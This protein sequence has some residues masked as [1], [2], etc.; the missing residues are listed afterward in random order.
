MDKARHQR[1]RGW[2][3]RLRWVAATGFVCFVAFSI[4]AFALDERADYLCDLSGGIALLALLIGG[5]AL[6]ALRLVAFTSR[7]A[8]K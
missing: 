1:R 2:E 4:P 7:R 6:V 8:L 5:L 3:G